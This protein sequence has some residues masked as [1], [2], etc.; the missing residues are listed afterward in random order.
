M[1]FDLVDDA[2]L[3]W[4]EPNEIETYDINPV[5]YVVKPTNKRIA[6]FDTE[7]DPF[8]FGLA[9]KPFTCGFATDT[10]HD[11]DTGNFDYAINGRYYK[12]FWGSDCVHQFFEWLRSMEGEYIIYVH[13]GGNFDFYFMIEYID[14]G[15][16][17][18][19]I[20]GRLAKLI[21]QGQEFRDSYSLLPVALSA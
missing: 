19:I 4:P 8:Q 1:S 13:N 16:A 12:D 21:M 7:T 5:P 10:P 14:R 20:N 11:A 6:T 15:S 2:E 17:P 18:F 3:A 9:V